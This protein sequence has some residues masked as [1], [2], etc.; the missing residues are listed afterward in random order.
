MYSQNKLIALIESKAKYYRTSI[1][2]VN[3]INAAGIK[4][5]CCMIVELLLLNKSYERIKYVLL[6]TDNTFEKLIEETYEF[7]NNFN[8]KQN[9]DLLKF[10]VEHKQSQSVWNKIVT[11]I[12]KKLA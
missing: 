2:F 5:Q 11:W 3:A 1:D 9:K 6:F 12:K 4:R 8:V 7:I 10:K